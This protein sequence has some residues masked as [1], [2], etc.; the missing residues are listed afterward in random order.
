MM[1]TLNAYQNNYLIVIVFL[2]LGILL[3]IA[4]LTIARI[5]RPQKKISEKY[6]TYESGIEPFHD[7]RVQFNVQYYLFALLF[8]M[9]DIETIFL[10]PWAVAFSKLGIFGVVKMGIFT[11][12]LF[13][14]LV[15]SWKKKVLKWS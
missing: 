1:T 2:I 6:T 12:L 3:P 8:V 5:L 4:A 7:A 11:F 15:Y 9:F 10:F 14:G 13:L